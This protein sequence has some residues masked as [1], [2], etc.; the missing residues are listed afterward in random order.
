[1]LGPVPGN[2][3][4]AD[5][6]VP[7]LEFAIPRSICCEVLSPSSRENSSYQTATPSLRR[8]GERPHKAGLVWRGRLMKTSGLSAM[9][10]S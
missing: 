5:D 1:M 8:L 10:L 9:T 3:S 4:R 6:E 2:E 7:T